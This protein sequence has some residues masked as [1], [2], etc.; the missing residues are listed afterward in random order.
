MQQLTKLKKNGYKVFEQENG[1][2]TGIS[3]QASSKKVGSSVCN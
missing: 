1:N 3:M 2:L